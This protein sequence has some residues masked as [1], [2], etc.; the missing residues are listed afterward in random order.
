MMYKAYGE[1][2]LNYCAFYDLILKD[3]EVIRRDCDL[4]DCPFYFIIFQEELKILRNL[5]KRKEFKR[6]YQQREED[7]PY[8]KI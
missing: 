5:Y 8:L 3:T 7:K 4:K 6:A 2:L 1:R